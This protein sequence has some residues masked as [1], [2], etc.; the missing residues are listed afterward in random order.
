MFT[1][2]RTQAKSVFVKQATLR[3]KVKRVV[4]RYQDNSVLGTKK[5]AQK[6]ER[7]T[8]EDKRLWR[9]GLQR[10]IA[11]VRDRFVQ[12]VLAGV[13]PRSKTKDRIQSVSRLE[14]QLLQ[15]MDQK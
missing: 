12:R 8:R 5:G 7:L 1:Y 14:Q 4:R 11:A 13:K 9:E 6:F 2:N 15:D 10:A 3:S